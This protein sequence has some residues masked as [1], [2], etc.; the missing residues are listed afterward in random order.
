MADI[1]LGVEYT[2]RTTTEAQ[3]E[4]ARVTTAVIQRLVAQGVP[5]D[6]IK[7]AGFGL[8]PQTTYDQQSRTERLTGYRV[9]NRLTVTVT[10]LSRVGAVV[11]AAIAAGAT[12]V[13][14]VS[15][16]AQDVSSVKAEAL[17]R[18]VADARAK[19]EAIAAA[20]GVKLGRVLSAADD[21]TSAGPPVLMRLKSAEA[22]SPTPFLPG[23]VKVHARVAVQFALE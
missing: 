20:L 17:R 13:F 15:F 18:A 5:A 19:A 11:D 2:G 14:D 8:Y 7:S 9:S 10:D 22:A 23:G 16:T 1:N 4:N 12:N 21:T 6:R 3:R